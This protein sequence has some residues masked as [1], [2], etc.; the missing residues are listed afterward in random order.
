LDRSES[1]Y[2]APRSKPTLFSRMFLGRPKSK[3]Q[4]LNFATLK[5][6]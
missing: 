1:A 4:R 3:V 2:V 5:S 6:G